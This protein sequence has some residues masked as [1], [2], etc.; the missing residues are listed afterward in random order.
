MN[1]YDKAIELG[2]QGDTSADAVAK[3]KGVTQADIPAVDVKDYFRSSKLWRET[4]EGAMVGDLQDAYEDT[5]SAWSQPVHE[6][7]KDGLNDLFTALYR[8]TTDHIH[9][10]TNADVAKQVI[11]VMNLLIAAGYVTTG[12]RDGLYALDGGLIFPSLTESQYDSDKTAHLAAETAAA[13]QSTLEQDL[14][15]QINDYIMPQ[16]PNGRS[17]VAAAMRSSADTL[18]G[19]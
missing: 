9:T 15:T 14:A 10:G 4:P 7:V 16:V 8:G 1:A 18:E 12:Q 19:V 13:T 11:D 5:T 6:S 17:S 2:I 3:L